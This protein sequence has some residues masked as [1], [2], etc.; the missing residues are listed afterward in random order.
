MLIALVSFSFFAMEKKHKS[1]LFPTQ[2]T[3][4]EMKKL[5][6]NK[7][8][9]KLQILLDKYANEDWEKRNPAEYNDIINLLE[10][11]RDLSPSNWCACITIANHTICLPALA[12]RKECL[13]LFSTLMSLF[14]KDYA[15]DPAQEDKKQTLTDILMEK[16]RKNVSP[17]STQMYTI[18]NSYCQEYKKNKS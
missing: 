12:A 8:E 4:E 9:K 6:K 2:E 17:R 14:E 7:I 11:S 18:L 16:A 10:S 1:F 15:F 13:A 5:L 3:D